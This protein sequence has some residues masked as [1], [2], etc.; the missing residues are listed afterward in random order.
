MS[1]CWRRYSYSEL[2]LAFAVPNTMK[3]GSIRRRLKDPDGL[4]PPA[5]LPPARAR[6][7]AVCQTGFVNRPPPSPMLPPCWYCSRQNATAAGVAPLAGRHAGVAPLA[8]RIRGVPPLN[9]Q[10]GPLSGLG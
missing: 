7:H 3:L 2:V 6:R 10:A 9:T 8:E 5:V 4:A 1:G